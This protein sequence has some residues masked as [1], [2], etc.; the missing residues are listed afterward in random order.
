MRIKARKWERWVTIIEFVS[1]WTCYY[2]PPWTSKRS[3]NNSYFFKTRERRKG[4]REKKDD[5]RFKIDAAWQIIIII[6]N[7]SI[8]L[9]LHYSGV[10]HRSFFSFLGL[11][12]CCCVLLHERC[13][14]SL[15]KR[16]KSAYKRNRVDDDYVCMCVC[17]CERASMRG[18]RKGVQWRASSERF[19]L[20]AKT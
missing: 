15:H 4:R 11:S 2:W 6:N 7:S 3:I 14:V 19:C 8:S 1:E 18:S 16:Y 9:S 5:F 17:V 10:C 12:D 20:N 13:G